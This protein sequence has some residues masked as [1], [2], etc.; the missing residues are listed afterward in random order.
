MTTVPA[1]ARR[2]L[3]AVVAIALAGGAA[4][5][6]ISAS[7][8]WVVEEGVHLVWVE[9]PEQLGVDTFG[10]WWQWVVPIVGGLLVGLGQRFL[11]DVPL[12]IAEVLARFRRGDGVDPQ[13]VP[14]AFVMA[15]V[16]LVAGGALGFEAALACLIG[17]IAT[18]IGRRSG[19]WAP[20][21]R[22]AWGLGE[23]VGLPAPIRSATAWLATIA[24]VVTYLWLPFGHVDLG[25]RLERYEGLPDPAD[26]LVLALFGVVAA[27]PVAWALALVVRSEHAPFVQRSPI[28]LGIAGGVVLAVLGAVD[29]LVLFSGQQGLATMADRSNVELAVLAIAKW[30]ALVVMMLA[31]WRGG[32]IFPLFL[33]FAAL[34]VLVG[35]AFGVPY[36]LAAVAGMTV[37]S[38]VFLRGRIVVSVVLTLYAVPVTYAGTMLLVAGAAAAGLLV[39]DAL[40]VL[41][42]AFRAVGSDDEPTA[43]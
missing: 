13:L 39:S 36:E 37:V 24:G 3:L 10:S 21:L 12:P 9:L 26:G 31:G 27:V 30:V 15:G 42:P 14:R 17:G 23:G 22:A 11:G 7:F 6:L 40:G 32:P 2:S 35:N 29:D 1:L 19:A 25:F 38:A 20:E 16:A 33:S 34:A 4:A 5:G 43:G 8:I 18:W 41:P 28:V